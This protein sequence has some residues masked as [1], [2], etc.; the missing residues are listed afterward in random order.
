[1]RWGAEPMCTVL[2]EHGVEIAPATYYEW[3]DKRPTAR[4]LRDEQVTALIGA[5]RSDPNFA[6][7]RPNHAHR[8]E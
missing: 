1:M 2:S 8:A 6:R 5:E 3:V 7:S 4:Q